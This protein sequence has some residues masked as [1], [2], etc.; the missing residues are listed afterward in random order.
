[1]ALAA[2]SVPLYVPVLLG[3]WGVL[4]WFVWGRRMLR[5]PRAEIKR[6]A[7]FRARSRVLHALGGGD[8]ET[9]FKRLWRMRWV[10]LVGAVLWVFAVLWTFVLALRS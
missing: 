4:C 1:V 7:D 9:E 2:E 8:A 5:D 6:W 3:A 10:A